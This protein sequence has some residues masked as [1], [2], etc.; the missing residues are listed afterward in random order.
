MLPAEKICQQV[1]L[2]EQPGMRCRVRAVLE[3]SSMSAQATRTAPRSWPRWPG[4]I[5]AAGLSWSTGASAQTAGDAHRTP[6]DNVVRSDQIQVAN[7]EWRRLSQSEVNCVDRW[8]RTQGSN[9]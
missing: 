7:S 2:A 3:M 6:A 5:V 8:Y 9:R 4:M 1:G